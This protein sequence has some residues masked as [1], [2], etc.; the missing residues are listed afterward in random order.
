VDIMSLDDAIASESPQPKKGPACWTVRAEAQF[1]EGWPKVM[2]LIEKVRDGERTA[3]SLAR[4][5]NKTGFR[6]SGSQVLRHVRK[7]C[8]C[9]D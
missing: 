4:I 5:L 7:D 2:D 9:D 3:A 8:D 6:I 1:G